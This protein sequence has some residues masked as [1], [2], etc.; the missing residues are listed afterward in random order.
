MR[1]PAPDPAPPCVPAPLQDSHWFAA[2]VHAHDGQLKAYLRG[3]FP[4]VRDID[5]IVQE[6]YLR[7]WKA[8]ADQPIASA[9]A[10][11]FRIARHA[12]VDLVRRRRNSPIIAVGDLAALPVLEDGP[13]VAEQVSTAEKLRLLGDALAALPRRCRE[14]IMLCK[15]NGLTHAEAAAQLGIS[16]KTA[17]EHVFRGLKRLDAEMRRRGIDGDFG[18]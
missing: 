2:E 3:S 5:D 7:I 6:S 18:G 1:P 17:D 9:R 10:F 16:V 11:L 15:I 8:G 14:L 4:T 13:G 12:A